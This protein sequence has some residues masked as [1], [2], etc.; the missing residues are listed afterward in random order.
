MCTICGKQFHRSD[1]LKLHSYSHTDERP[2]HCHICGKGFKMNY[3]LK[4]HLKNHDHE[5]SNATIISS[6][7]D[8]TTFNISESSMNSNKIELSLINTSESNSLNFMDSLQDNDI[9]V[10]NRIKPF[11]ATEGLVN[12]HQ[13]SI[14]QSM[15]FNA[16]N[17]N[18]IS[19]NEMVSYIVNTNEDMNRPINLAGSTRNFVDNIAKIK[20]M[21]SHIE[22]NQM[23][24]SH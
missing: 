5:L 19:A 8:T 3:N 12:S 18:N 6:N 23:F 2:F 16:S 9:N 11:I 21:Q 13:Q 22:D 15:N 20:L 24:G 17:T 14:G 10:N 1:Y 7:E 4:V